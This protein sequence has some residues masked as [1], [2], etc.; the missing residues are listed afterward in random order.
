MRG[1]ESLRRA[2]PLVLASVLWAAA[3]PALE[4]P[5]LA[6]R[7]NDLAGLLDATVEQQIEAKL[8]QLEKETGAQV[9][10]L[11]LAS[12]EDEPVEDFA[13]RVVET[14]KLGREGIDDGALLLISRDDRKIRIEVGYG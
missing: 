5:Y 9:A 3:L 12:L 10:V 14:W 6:G 13:L 1:F 11:T 4:V 7:V 2:L 8:E